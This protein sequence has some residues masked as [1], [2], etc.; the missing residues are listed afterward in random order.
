MC[1]VQENKERAQKTMMNGKDKTNPVETGHFFIFKSASMFVCGSIKISKTS[2]FS[3]R[4]LVK[5]IQ[6]CQGLATIVFF[7][8]L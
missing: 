7:E 1:N 5:S 3:L 6:T 2:D 8:N 4:G